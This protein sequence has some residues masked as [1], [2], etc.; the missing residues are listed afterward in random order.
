MLNINGV[1]TTL[2]ETSDATLLRLCHSHPIHKQVHG[3]TVLRSYSR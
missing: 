3:H 2:R 1:Q